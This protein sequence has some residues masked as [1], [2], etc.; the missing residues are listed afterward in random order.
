MERVPNGR[1]A[2][3]C[4]IKKVGNKSIGTRSIID[5]IGTRSRPKVFLPNDRLERVP[6]LFWERVPLDLF[7]TF[8][9]NTFPPMDRLGPLSVLVH[10]VKGIKNFSNV[11]DIL[12]KFLLQNVLSQFRQ[13]SINS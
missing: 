2:G 12:L 10:N 9:W 5:P 1:W 7:P 3:T 8:L 11:K 13:I 6:K 4:S